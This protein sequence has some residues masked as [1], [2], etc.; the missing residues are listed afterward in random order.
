MGMRR[1][2]SRT[3]SEPFDATLEVAGVRGRP[4]MYD[5]LDIA[6]LTMAI[7]EAEKR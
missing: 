6:R 1:L 4:V 7:M 3:A 5:I 2:R